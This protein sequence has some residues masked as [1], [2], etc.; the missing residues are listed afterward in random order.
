MPTLSEV[1][2]FIKENNHLPDIASAD[3]MREDGMNL[4]EMQTKLLQKLEEM[5]LYII[6]LN[7]RNELQSTEIEQLKQSIAILKMQ[8]KRGL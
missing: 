6:L 4:S 7:K 8:N 2:S 5:S 1:E 3:E